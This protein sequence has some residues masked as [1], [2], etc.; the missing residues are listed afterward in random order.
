M[1]PLL[2]LLACGQ[3]TL[4]EGVRLVYL[5]D[6]V[7]HWD[8]ATSMVPP[9]HLPQPEADQMRVSVQLRLPADGTIDLR[10][11]HDGRVLPSWPPGTV[12]DR[13][14]VRG[15]QGAER[16]VDVR[17][18]RIDADG[19][20]WNHVY[21]PTSPDRSAPLLGV[22]WP[23]GDARL[24]AAAVDAF[25]E[26][27]GASPMIQALDDPEA[28]LAGV[29]SKL[30]CDGCHVPARRNNRKNN[31]N[32][33]VNRGTDHAGWFTPLTLLTSSVPLEIYGVFDP[34]LADPFVRVACP[35]GEAVVPSP[36]GNRHA[37]CPDGA[38]PVGTLAVA[39]A[40]EAGDAHAR[41]YC[42]V[43]NE[44]IDRLEPSAQESIRAR[45]PCTQPPRDP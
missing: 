42:R 30:G 32:G 18:M 14:E 16:V 44:L 9:V 45:H 6:P 36:G 15:P 4:P 22:T 24:G 39:E 13:V 29:R 35:S 23:A 10:P 28:H 40:L 8:D 20:R 27:L 11:T 3:P 38:V 25:I 26:G 34:N 41:D 1:S 5:E 21:R 43:A 7:H 37:S 19:R 12:A 2:S 31:Q 33:L 17:G